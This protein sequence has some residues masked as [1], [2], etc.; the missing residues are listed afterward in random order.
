MRVTRLGTGENW[1]SNQ[2][3][4]HTYF[5]KIRRKKGSSD[6]FW[7]EYYIYMCVYMHMYIYDRINKI[8]FLFFILLFPPC[9]SFSLY[10]PFIYSHTHKSFS[11][12]L[13]SVRLYL[14]KSVCINFFY[15]WVKVKVTQSCLTL[16][17]HGLYSPW[18]SPGQNTGV[19]SLSLLQ[20]IFSTQGSNPGL[21]G[22]RQ[23]LYQL[24]YRGSP[25]LKRVAI[26]TMAKSV[27]LIWD[28]K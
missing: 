12:K 27:Y 15:S 7:L 6:K 24:S 14:D 18:N 11:F 2:K 20:E 5:L 23:I 21:S 13:S 16:R 9:F 19:G 25:L 3:I 8:P 17:P 22:C 10:F 4:A 1:C 26:N 28:N